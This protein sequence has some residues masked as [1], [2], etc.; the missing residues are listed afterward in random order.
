M[1]WGALLVVPFLMNCAPCQYCFDGA[2]SGVT[3]SSTFNLDDGVYVA[4]YDSACPDV[5]YQTLDDG[6]VDPSGIILTADD[7]SYPC[8]TVSRKSPAPI[9]V[10][11]RERA[12]EVALMQCRRLNFDIRAER[13][14][15]DGV[16][17]NQANPPNW[18][19]PSLCTKVRSK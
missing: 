18:Y 15:K 2:S 19:F 16:F 3:R 12:F 6:T 9:A 11:D 10:T 5:W 8:S 7:G 14:S 4:E 1:R 17:F 13:T